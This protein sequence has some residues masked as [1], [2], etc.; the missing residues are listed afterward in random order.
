MIRI[1]FRMTQKNLGV[2]ESSKK[3]EDHATTE[4]LGA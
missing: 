2:M 1:T 4:W 3:A